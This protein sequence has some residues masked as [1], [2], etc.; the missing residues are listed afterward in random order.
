MLAYLPYRP[1]PADAV[2]AEPTAT[3][4]EDLEESDTA[5]EDEPPA[6]AAAAGDKPPEATAGAPPSVAAAGVSSPADEGEDVPPPPPPPLPP[7]EGTAAP[8]DAPV[9]DDQVSAALRKIASHIGHLKKFSKASQLLRE[10]LSQVKMHGT[11]SPQDRSVSLWHRACFSN[12]GSW[13]A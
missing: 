13:P 11:G 5:A 12:F 3:D 8:A 10:L 7:A 6:A 1:P 9:A 4:L 2:V